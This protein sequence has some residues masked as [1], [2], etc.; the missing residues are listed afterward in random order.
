MSDELKTFA[1]LATCNPAR[2][3]QFYVS[4]LDEFRDVS[5]HTE[6][7]A[8]KYADRMNKKYGKPDPRDE[9]I[10]IYEA[11]LKATL[12][13]CTNDECEQCEATR[14]ALARAKELKP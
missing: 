13:Q 1:I 6:Y 5:F 12:D 10:A 14:Q 3:P 8:R 11:A 9:V 7:D 2:E 4:G